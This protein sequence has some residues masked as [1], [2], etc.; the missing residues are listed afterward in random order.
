MTHSKP[1]PTIFDSVISPAKCRAELNSAAIFDCRAKLGDPAWGHQAFVLGHLPGAQHLD[2][3]Q[4]LA[5]PPDTRGRHPLPPMDQWLATIQRLGVRND[6]QVIVYDDAGGAFAAR[7]WWMFRWVG[8][9]AVAVLDGGLGAWQQNF[10]DQMEQGPA[11]PGSPSHF[12]QGPSLTRYIDGN[13]L[14]AAIL[15]AHPPVLLDARTHARWAG[16]EEPID[17]VAGHIPGAVCLPFQDN[18]D[19]DGY[20]KSPADLAARFAPHI[21]DRGEIICYC[22]SGVTAA[23]NLLA[24]HI[25]GVSEAVLYPDSWSGWITHPSRPVATEEV[26]P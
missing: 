1:H 24:L 17:P 21:Q 15:D 19:A 23:H 8:H 5:L 18:L 12:S 11:A 7:A 16:L 20:F 10:A 13:T 25:A 14:H 3:D 9:R 4:D 2:L 22:G 6:Q 26:T